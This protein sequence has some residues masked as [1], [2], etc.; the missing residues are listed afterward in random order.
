MHK[1]TNK[2]CQKKSS[3]LLEKGLVDIERPTNCNAATSNKK[4][5]VQYE[6][7]GTEGLVYYIDIT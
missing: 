4:Y 2:S 6:I 3:S 1:N 5:T 7:K